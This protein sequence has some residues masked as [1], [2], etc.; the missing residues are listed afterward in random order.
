MLS[1]YDCKIK[2]IIKSLV[3]SARDISRLLLFKDLFIGLDNFMSLLGFEPQD[4]TVKTLNIYL[5][6]YLY[7]RSGSELNKKISLNLFAK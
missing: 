1:D 6:L 5:Y 4:S 3:S 2:N 7:H